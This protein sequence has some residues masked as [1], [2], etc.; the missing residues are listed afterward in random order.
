MCEFIMIPFFSLAILYII[1]LVSDPN[2][3]K[4]YNDIHVQN[5]NNIVETDYSVQSY[6]ISDEAI[7]F[8]YQNGNVIS[9]SHETYSI[10]KNKPKTTKAIKLSGHATRTSINL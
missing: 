8:Y 10:L 2:M 3:W 4:F 6:S 7:I 9:L 5:I 1:V